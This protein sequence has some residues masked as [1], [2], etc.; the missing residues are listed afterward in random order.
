[1]DALE[2]EKLN[3]LLKYIE[4]NIRSSDT[5][6]AKYIDP[7]GNIGRLNSKQNQVIYGRRGSGKSLLITALKENS[8]GEA[9]FTKINIEDFKDVSFPDSLLQAIKSFLKQLDT[10]VCSSYKWYQL[11]RLFAAKSIHRKLK[12]KIE[13]ITKKLNEPDKYEQNITDTDS[14]KNT[15]KI[16]GKDKVISAET[17]REDFAEH[18]VN[19]IF[20]VEKLD[21]LKKE[22]PDLKETINE[23]SAFLNNRQIFLVLDD[24]YFL[25]KTD[26]PYFVD[27][28]HRLSK[29]TKLFI[30]V[31]TIKHRSALYV[32]TNTYIGMEMGHDAQPIELDYTLDKYDVLQDFMWQILKQINEDSKANL[33]IE[34]LLSDNAFKYLCIASGGV[35]RDFLSLFIRVGE[36]IKKESSSD[37]RVSKPEVIDIAISNITNKLDSLKTDSAEEKETLEHYLNYIKNY[38]INEVKTNIFLLG[39]NDLTSQPQ[40]NQA[41]KELVDFRLIHQIEQNIS[42]KHGG[43]R[44]A[45]YMID[46]GF[47]PTSRNTKNFSVIEPGMSDQAG[48]DAIRSSPKIEIDKIKE[49]INSLVINKELEVTL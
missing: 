29:D 48:R 2:K 16:A 24:F 47:F 21:K 34:G 11:K 14:S 5:T 40:I 46:V 35:V 49:H 13:D 41:I 17:G 8:K 45:A 4:E 7:Y 6:Q 25:K 20:P 9:I 23:I 22:I 12:K 39:I 10:H 1:M 36:E 32:N 27:F 15:N 44:Y 31:A 33:K 28:F 3:I 18:K 30:K 42:T 43:Q 37:I 19:K 38:M 26:Q